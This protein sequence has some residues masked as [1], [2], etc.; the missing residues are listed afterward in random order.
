MRIAMVS[1]SADAP[2]PAHGPEAD[3]HN[4]RV[5]DLAAALVRHG[6]QV[7]VY[8]R[9]ADPDQQETVR[10]EGGYDVVHV[11]AG[12]PRPMARDDLLPT[13]GEFTRF[14]LA[15]WR[16]D[17][18]DVAHAHFW[19]CGLA[20]TLA[21]RRLNIPTVQTFSSLGAVS[22]RHEGAA[23]AY[24]ADRI[25]TERLIG[26]R[27]CRI[28]AGCTDEV[29]EL[30]RMGVPRSKIS[31]IPCGVDVHRF[32]PAGPTAPRELGHRIV[33][34]GKLVPRRG[35]LTIVRAMPMLPDTELV[36]AGGPAG[37]ALAA[38]RHAAALLDE[39]ERLGVGDRVWL[40]GQVSDADM[41]ALLRSADVAACVPWYE[42]SGV[43]PLQA[44]ACG[45]PVVAT[46]VG[47]LTDIVVDG[48][49]GVHVPPR[50]PEAFAAAVLGLHA[51]DVGRAALGLAGRERARARYK[52]DR[53]A[54]DVV[55]VYDR[56]LDH[57][58]P[59]RGKCAAGRRKTSPRWVPRPQR[60]RDPMPDPMPHPSTTDQEGDP[61]EPVSLAIPSPRDEEDLEPT[62][63]LGRE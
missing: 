7:T 10:V 56:A 50:D 31:V 37:A 13:M 63:V 40:A 20:T 60:R 6:H 1:E 9:R 46:A 26:D 53:I 39:A 38:D 55:R 2:A 16:D 34:V 62:I 57:G 59:D 19:M 28:A 52:W 33:T 12:P 14:L 11:P 17:R 24:P 3:G 32:V 29:F 21:G 23:D 43:A 61:A 5:A 4:Q 25:E 44:M 41:P 49:T 42:P 47:A 48:V 58:S 8:T 51:D 54:L 45:V 36:I 27:A 22:R 30:I 15:R 35:F 18:P